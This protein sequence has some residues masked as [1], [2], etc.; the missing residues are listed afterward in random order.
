MSTLA[1]TS[2]LINW[3]Y[4][5]LNFLLGVSY[6]YVSDVDAICD[7][8]ISLTSVLVDNYCNLEPDYLEIR[9][10]VGYHGDISPV[11]EFNHHN[12]DVMASTE[13]SRT[14]TSN[15][16]TISRTLKASIDLDGT[17]FACSVKDAEPGR[18]ETICVTDD[19]SVMCEI[20]FIIANF[21][22]PFTR[23]RDV[24]EATTHEA[25]AVA[26]LEIL[27]IFIQLTY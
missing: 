13:V 12:R 6:N 26:H 21:E 15:T 9:C 7:S 18:K 19:I 2:N 3:K 25:E 1:Y 23:S 10:S 20:Y 16:T 8:N 22:L 11:L 17:N 24:N 5:R 4:L 14:S 27:I